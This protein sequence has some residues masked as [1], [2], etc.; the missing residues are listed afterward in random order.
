MRMMEDEILNGY[1]S[2]LSELQQKAFAEELEKWHRGETHGMT[3]RE[4][5]EDFLDRFKKKYHYSEF[6]S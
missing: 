6:K 3:A 2:K 1:Y 5:L 4:N